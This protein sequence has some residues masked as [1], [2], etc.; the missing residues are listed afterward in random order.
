MVEDSYVGH[1]GCH[2][3]FAEGIDYCIDLEKLVVGNMLVNLPRPRFLMP[4][5]VN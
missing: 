1:Y 5:P 2:G 3:C 4:S